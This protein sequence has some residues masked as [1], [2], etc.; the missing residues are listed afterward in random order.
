M[1]LCFLSLETG[2]IFNKAILER[3]Q[4]SGFE[5]LS[6]A[7]IILFPYIEQSQKISS[8]EL[9]RQMGYSRQAM[10]KNIKKLEELG[11]VSLTLQNQKEK[12]ITFTAKG[13]HL[14]QEATKI[15]KGIEDDLSELIGQEKLETY[16][17]NQAAIH[18]YLH[19]LL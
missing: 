11:Y 16:K 3:L 13:E 18:A 9:S 10:H 5:G 15:I 4:K 1:S 8:A 12:I 19:S 14:M 2:K 17:S 7:L 6:E